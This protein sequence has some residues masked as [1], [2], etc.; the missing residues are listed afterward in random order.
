[1]L[2]FMA[3]T[4]SAYFTKVGTY[5]Y[6]DCVHFQKVSLGNPDLSYRVTIMKDSSHPADI[7]DSDS[8]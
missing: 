1:M 7:R 8:F 6:S 2:A 4:Q 3:Q 5:P